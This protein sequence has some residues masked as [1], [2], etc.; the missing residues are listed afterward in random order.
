MPRFQRLEFLH[1]HPGRQQNS[2]NIAQRSRV[3]E[4]VEFEDKK[5]YPEAVAQIALL[6]LAKTADLDRSRHVLVKGVGGIRTKLNGLFHG[7][8]LGS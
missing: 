2:P 5:V 8:G 1:S 3:I 4:V 6:S 7:G